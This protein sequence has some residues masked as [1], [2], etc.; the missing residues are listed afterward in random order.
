MMESLMK[1]KCLLY[2]SIIFWNDKML[3]QKYSF[4]LNALFMFTVF[5]GSWIGGEEMGH[6]NHLILF[7][8]IQ[9]G[10]IDKIAKLF[11]C[12]TYNL[13]HF[14]V[15]FNVCLMCVM[16]AI[17]CGLLGWESVYVNFSRF[18][19]SSDYCGWSKNPIEWKF[20]KVFFFLCKLVFHVSSV[21]FKLSMLIFC[22]V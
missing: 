17:C 19:I 18:F 21:F 7:L 16:A 13:L 9:L 15:L 6:N 14:V 3:S 10:I 2:F 11:F 20:A 12:W 22:L 8:F 5:V 1:L 4:G